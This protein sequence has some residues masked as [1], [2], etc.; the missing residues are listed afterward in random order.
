MEDSECPNWLCIQLGSREH[1]AIPRA[2]NMR[3]KLLG[4]VTDSWV[5]P[6]LH[7]MMR[8]A[9]IP[10][11]ADRYH[12]ELRSVAVRALTHQRLLSELSAKLR[13]VRGWERIE[14]RD[15]WFQAE[16]VRALKRDQNTLA[17]STERGVVFAYCYAARAP[18]AFLK[19]MGFKVILGQIDPGPKELNHV[20]AMMRSYPEFVARGEVPSDRYWTNWREECQLADRILVNSEWSAECITQAGINASRIR[21]IP[22]A[23]ES[24]ETRYVHSRDYPSKF[25]GQRPLRVLFRGQIIPRKG[26]AQLLEA[27]RRAVDLPIVFT[28]AGPIGITLPPWVSAL[29]NVNILGPVPRSRSSE[30]YRSSDVFI[31]PS[32]SEGF[33]ITQLEA[34]SEQLP[35]IVSKYC[36]RVIEDGYNGIVLEEVTPEAILS[37][38]MQCL[39]G[40][41]LARMESVC[42]VAGEYDLAALSDKLMKIEREVLGGNNTA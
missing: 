40:N 26:I 8:A 42:R 1:Y 37:A 16:V 5:P 17:R 11:L 35:C 33:A 7:W 34:L 19:S 3:G 21:I 36:A 20:D 6:R 14:E 10:E 23:F 29:P 28:F 2:L 9:R 12:P 22:L 39:E 4:L 15:D 13:H 31:L 18:I 41:R 25:S 32:L 38:L 24:P 27:A 30:L